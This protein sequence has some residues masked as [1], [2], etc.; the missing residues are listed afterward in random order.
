MTEE[1]SKLRTVSAQQTAEQA[2][3]A[4]FPIT[5]AT[6]EHLK[7]AWDTNADDCGKLVTCGGP[8]FSRYFPDYRGP[9][10]REAME[11]TCLKCGSHDVQFY[12]YG[13]I[14]RFGLCQSHRDI[15]SKIDAPGTTNPVVFKIPGIPHL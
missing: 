7:T 10:T 2:L 9:L 4:G 12:V 3:K 1:V 14:N 5:C 8:I 11:K 15:F 13:G 6:C